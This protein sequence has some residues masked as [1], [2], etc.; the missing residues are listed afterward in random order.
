MAVSHD[1]SDSS[2]VTVLQ[3]ESDE[4]A[5]VLQE[6]A[7]GK[8]VEPGKGLPEDVLATELNPSSVSHSDSVRFESD[9]E[10]GEAL[11][12]SADEAFW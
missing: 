3:E 6:S 5:E 1:V 11:S 10:C 12:D 4:A 9:A 2:E 8:L 7:E